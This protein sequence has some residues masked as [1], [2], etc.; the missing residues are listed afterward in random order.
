V[1]STH[2]PIVFVGQTQEIQQ[3]PVQIANN[4]SAHDKL[5]KSIEFTQQVETRS[6]GV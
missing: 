3:R 4:G 1:T 5:E 2:R 6:A